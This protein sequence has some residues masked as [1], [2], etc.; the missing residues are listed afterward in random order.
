MGKWDIVIAHPHKRI[1]DGFMDYW[2]LSSYRETV[3]LRVFTRCDA[4]RHYLRSQAGIHMLVTEFELLQNLVPEE[5]SEIIIV[6]LATDDR[7]VEC[8]FPYLVENPYQSLSQLFH[9]LIEHC[10]SK[11][12]QAAAARSAHQCRIVGI[13]SAGGGAGKT[14]VAFH[15]AKHAASLGRRT[16][17]LNIDPMHE[18]GLLQQPRDESDQGAAPLSQLLYYVRREREERETLCVPLERYTVSMPALGTSTFDA[19]QMMK[20]WHEIDLKLMQQLLH[21]LQASGRFDLIVV[22]GGYAHPPF[23]AVWKL[24]G[25]IIWLLIDDWGH[26]YKSQLIFQKWMRSEEEDCDQ[27]KPVNLLVNRYLGTMVNCWTC[28]EAAITG[29]LPYIPAWKQ[30]HEPKQWLQS[31]IFESIL[32]NWAETHLNLMGRNSLKGTVQ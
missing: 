7:T 5:V 13:T 19:W 29:F 14:T 3:Q 18:Y 1:L 15:L 16:F 26:M 25:Y 27:S 4:L 8:T 23:A 31:A 17:L 9:T 20:E 30:I 21:Y 2:K 10:Q 28:R 12:C 24:N 11:W 22:E 6:V 32:A